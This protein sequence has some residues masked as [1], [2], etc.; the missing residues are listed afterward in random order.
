[1]GFSRRGLRRLTMGGNLAQSPERPRLTASFLV[2]AG[3]REGFPGMCARLLRVAG[4][5][6]YLTERGDPERLVARGSRH[7]LLCEPECLGQ[8]PGQGIRRAQDGGNDKKPVGGVHSLGQCNGAFERGK[9]LGE[10]SFPE[11][12]IANTPIGP[13]T[14]E[15]VPD[16]LGNPDPVFCHGHAIDKRSHL[17]EAQRQPDM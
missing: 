15:G 14:A 12:H 11:G 16:C 1:V 10:V 9:S 8:A 2:G 7:H 6:I 5:Q 17:G 4:Q 13:N 3:K